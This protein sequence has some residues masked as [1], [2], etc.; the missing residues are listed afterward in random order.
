SYNPST[1]YLPEV[2]NNPRETL[3]DIANIMEIAI[4][5]LYI[6][7]LIDWIYRYKKYRKSKKTK[8]KENQKK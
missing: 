4:K 7:D 5:P 8:Q 6:L 3:S 2:S 1:S